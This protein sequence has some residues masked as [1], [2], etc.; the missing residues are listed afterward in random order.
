M[1]EAEEIID[2]KVFRIGRVVRGRR[3]ERVSIDGGA[4][5]VTLSAREVGGEEGER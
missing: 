5:R 3:G 1:S 4:V 2:N